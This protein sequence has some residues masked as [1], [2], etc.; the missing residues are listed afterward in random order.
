ME[1]IIKEI[2]TNEKLL[3][4]I[5]EFFRIILLGIIPI[6]IEG[7]SN[8]EINLKLIGITGAIAGLK[9]IDKYLHKTGKEIDFFQKKSRNK[10]TSPLT[11]GLTRF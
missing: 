2:I 3:E 7:L 10:K 1:K 11:R 5:K 9:F 8:G 4:A 6:T